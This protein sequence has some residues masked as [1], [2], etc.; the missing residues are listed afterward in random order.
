ML[1]EI[2]IGGTAIIAHAPARPRD[3]FAGQPLVLAVELRAD[4]GTLELGGFHAGSREAWTWQMELLPLTAVKS[5]IP[6]GALYGRERIADLEAGVVGESRNHDERIERLGLRHRIVSRRT[7]LIAIA[8][9]PATDPRAPRR[10][11]RLAVEM[12]Y[13]VS[14]EGVGLGVSLTLFQGVPSRPMVGAFRRVAP[15]GATV[16]SLARVKALGVTPPTIVDAVSV[17]WLDATTV[18]IE[19]TTPH[20][21]FMLP[22]KDVNVEGPRG[23][24]CAIVDG[25][26][27][28]PTGPHAKG[29]ILRI[30]LRIEGKLA[31]SGPAEFVM[32][33]TA[34][35]R[36]F[37]LRSRKS[38]YAMTF[39]A[40]PPR[41]RDTG[42]RV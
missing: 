24:I 9:E 11:E 21:G 8:D 37:L 26:A 4:G 15:Y 30:A 18:I 27:S 16:A 38:S 35:S 36:T 7:S 20:D 33:W 2:S 6:L 32:R 23:A 31:S 28:S 10:R 3:V 25:D 41:G 12:P 1:T 13:G 29:L 17:V 5:L 14:A 42:T 39:M 34:I 22:I 40:P 19:F